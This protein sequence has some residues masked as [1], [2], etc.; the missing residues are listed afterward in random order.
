MKCQRLTLTA[1]V[2]MVVQGNYEEQLKELEDKLQQ[3]ECSSE[4]MELKKRKLEETCETM[5]KNLDTL[6]SHLQK[7]FIPSL[8]SC[9]TFKYAFQTHFHYC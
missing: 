4:E 6:E 2:G 8:L 5:Q 3:Y 1:S 9:Y 7:V